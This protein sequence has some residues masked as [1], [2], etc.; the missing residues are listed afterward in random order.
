MQCHVCT[1]VPQITPQGE[2]NIDF[3]PGRT[4]LPRNPH[5]ML[6]IRERGYWPRNTTGH[7]YGA[8]RANVTISVNYHLFYKIIIYLVEFW[9]MLLKRRKHMVE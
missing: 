3:R 2:P 1:A 7:V 4:I 5:P 9:L 8:V 6:N